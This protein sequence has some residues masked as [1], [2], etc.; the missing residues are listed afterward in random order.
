MKKSMLTILF[1]ISSNAF[2]FDEYSCQI[3][4]Q[5]TNSDNRKAEVAAENI[6]VKTDGRRI[7][8]GRQKKP[9]HDFDMHP[10]ARA[11]KISLEVEKDGN[12]TPLILTLGAPNQNASIG[13]AYGQAGTRYIG[14]VMNNRLEVLCKKL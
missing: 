14:L 4:G 3:Y 8:F 10:E 1:L 2:A 12:E 6:I 9:E 13:R 5:F 7:L 11:W